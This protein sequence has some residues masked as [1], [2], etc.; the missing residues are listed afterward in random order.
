MLLNGIGRFSE[1]WPSFPEKRKQK[2][3]SVDR[4]KMTDDVEV[5]N[6]LHNCYCVITHPVHKFV[7]MEYVCLSR[8]IV[9]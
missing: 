1:A 2:D 6:I 3:S 7:F 5:D 4:R 8:L 9:V